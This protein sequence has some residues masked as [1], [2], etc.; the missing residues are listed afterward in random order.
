MPVLKIRNPY[1]DDWLVLSEGPQGPPGESGS[2]GHTILDENTPMA[3][4]SNLS[5]SGI[6]V[7]VTDDEPN[8]VTIVTITAS[9]SGGGGTSGSGASSEL[10]IWAEGDSLAGNADLSYTNEQLVVSNEVVAGGLFGRRS[11]HGKNITL[12]SGYS[13]VVA[14]DFTIDENTSLT[15]EEDSV[16]EII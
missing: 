7:E 12:P 11:T 3:T 1:N 8:D 13:W 2:G 5:F 16:M 9:G 15:L 4:R 14:G 6:G 10:A